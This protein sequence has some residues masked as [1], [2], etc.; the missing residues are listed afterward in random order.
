MN[1]CVDRAGGCVE[2]KVGAG[3]AKIQRKKSAQKK[4]RDIC[5]CKHPCRDTSAK[6]SRDVYYIRDLRENFLKTEG[7]ESGFALKIA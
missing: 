2:P 3:S 5:G 6:N 4:E 1:Q 7:A